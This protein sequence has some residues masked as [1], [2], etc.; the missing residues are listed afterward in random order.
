MLNI[1]HQSSNFHVITNL[2]PST[3]RKYN[4][5]YCTFFVRAASISLTVNYIIHICLLNQKKVNFRCLYY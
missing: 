4:E 3:Y 1:S 2:K 5:R